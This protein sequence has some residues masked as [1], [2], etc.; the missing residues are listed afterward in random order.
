MSEA[1][2]WLSSLPMIDPEQAEKWADEIADAVEKESDLQG[3]LPFD[4]P[5]DS[6]SSID[7]PAYRILYVKT[8]GVLPDGISRLNFWM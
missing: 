2:R 6:N 3:T 8:S 1:F 7:R 4:R 5:I